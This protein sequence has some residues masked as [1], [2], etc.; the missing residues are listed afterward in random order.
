MSRMTLKQVQHRAAIIEPKA[1]GGLL[2]AIETYN[3]APETR[4]ALELL[5]LTFVRPGELR[6]AE[7]SEFDLD[8]G[9]W[10]IP[11]ERMRGRHRAPACPRR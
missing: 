4:A 11:G 7:W 1:F 6:A 2:R 9:V 5:G 8:T 10:S 3:G